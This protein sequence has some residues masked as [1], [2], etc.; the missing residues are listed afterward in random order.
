MFKQRK[1][2]LDMTCRTLIKSELRLLKDLPVFNAEECCNMEF[3]YEFEFWTN[4]CMQ[5]ISGMKLWYVA[6]LEV[7]MFELSLV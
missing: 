2:Q 3:E 4:I 7:R 6:V 5:I 1:F